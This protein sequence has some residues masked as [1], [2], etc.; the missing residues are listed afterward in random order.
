MDASGF[1]TGRLG[2][3]AA[4]GGGLAFALSLLFGAYQYVAIY[5]RA[6]AGGPRTSAV[7]IDT[8]LF[9]AFALHHSAFTR[10]GLKRQ[11]QRLVSPALERTVYVWIASALFAIVCGLWRPVPGIG[12]LASG[13]GAAVLTAIQLA[14][15]IV[16]LIASRQFDVLEL[17]GIRQASGRPSSERPEL[18]ATGLYGLV[19]HP[20]YFGWFLMVWPSPMMTGTRLV[21]AAVTSGYLLAAIPGEERGLRRVFGAA[22]DAYASRVRWRV[23]PGLY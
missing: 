5:G 1:S 13:A 6:G 4:L 10:A 18:L 17:A 2:R 15:V 8:L 3:A 7:A 9:T 19:R 14:G 21:F 22:Y 16:T 20:I 12:W 11:I 23:L